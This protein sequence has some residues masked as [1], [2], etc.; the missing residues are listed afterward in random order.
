MAEAIVQRRAMQ[1]RVDRDAREGEERVLEVEGQPLRDD[2]GRYFQYALIS[3]DITE[4]KRTEAPLR[5]S[6]EYFR[7]LFDE[8]PVPSTIISSDHR[9]VRANAAHTRMLG[10]TIDQMI[11]KDPLTFVHP[12]EV[13]T[14][15]AMRNEM[16]RVRRSAQQFTF[17]RR[18]LKGDGG[19]AWVRGHSVQF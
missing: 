5:E 8:S 3:P 10:Y 12:E 13:D 15:Y 1:D 14:A 4:R 18:M 11:G 16:D 9:I 7:A 2:Q 6:A 17:E 19:V